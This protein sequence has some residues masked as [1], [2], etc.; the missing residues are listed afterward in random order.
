M[1]A[2]I[3]DICLRSSILCSA[4]QEKLNRGEITESDVNVSRVVFKLSERFRTLR[5]VTIKKAIETKNN[6]VIIPEKG[7]SAKIIGRGGSIVRELSKNLNKNVRVI[8]ETNDK[9]DF[10]EKMVFPAK[11]SAINILYTENG[12]KLKIVVSNIK[13][14][15]ISEENLRE[16]VKKIFGQDIEIEN[17]FSQIY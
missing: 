11:V 6:I 16:V 9:R 3:C 2:P 14:L 5:D 1:K 15:P 13:K 8:E 12:E 7:D 4:C 10:I 17:N